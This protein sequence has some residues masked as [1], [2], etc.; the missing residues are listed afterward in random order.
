MTLRLTKSES[1]VLFQK[2]LNLGLPDEECKDRLRKV[3]KHLKLLQ[4]SLRMNNKTESEVNEAFYQEYEK[5]LM[6]AENGRF[7]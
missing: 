1:Q 5:L 2:Y 3:H 6:E 4:E 7:D